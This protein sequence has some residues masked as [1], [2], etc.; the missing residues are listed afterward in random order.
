MSNNVDTRVVEMQFNNAQ[1]EQGVSQTTSTLDKLKKAL[2]FSGSTKGFDEVNS[3]AHRVDLEFL[4]RRFGTLGIAG[5]TAIQNITNRLV[6]LGFKIK[7]TFSSS[8]IQGGFKRALNIEQAKFQIEGLHGVWDETSKG[9]KEGSK[10]IREAT[11]EAVKGTAYGLD[12]AAR[13]ASQLLASGIND[14]DELQTH[15]QSVAGVAAMTGGS[16]SEIGRIFTQTAGQGAMMGEQLMELSARGL[17]AASTLSDYFSTHSKEWEKAKKVL[18]KNDIEKLGGDLKKPTEAAI[19]DIAS[20]RGITFKMFSDA[21]NEAFGEHAKDANKTYTGSLMNMK[22]ALARIGADI[23]GDYLTNMRDIFNALTPVIDA[24]HTVMGPFIEDINKVQKVL[25]SNLILNLGVLQGILE[26]GFSGAEISGPGVALAHIFHGIG[27]AVSLVIDAF[28]VFVSFLAPIGG[29]LVEIAGRVGA[30]ISVLRKN[31][32]GGRIFD[33]ARLKAEEWGNKVADVILS[34]SDS[35]GPVL[36]KLISV[37]PSIGTVFSKALGKAMEIGISFGKFIS[38]FFS[39]LAEGVPEAIKL[40]GKGFESIGGSINR[41]TGDG[42]RLLNL[43][44]AAGIGVIVN[45]LTGIGRALKDPG[46]LLDNFFETMTHSAGPFKNAMW[47]VKNSMLQLQGALKAD[48]LMKIA[49]S[50]GIMAASLFLL[51]SI[52]ADKLALALGGLAGV[53]YIF[54]GLM[55]SMSSLEL[56]SKGSLFQTA[57]IAALAMSIE[58]FAVAILILVAGVKLLGSM[59]LDD[60]AKGLVGVGVLMAGVIAMAKLLGSENPAKMM[61]GI[62][63]MIAIAIA[64]D[65]LANAVKKLGSL[66]TEELIKGLGSVGLLMGAVAGLSHITGKIK[67][68]SGAAIFMIAEAID[69]LSN[70]VQKFAKM[71]PEELVKGLAAVGSM[72]LAIAGMSR[73][74]GSGGGILLASA[75]MLIMAEAMKELLPVIK[76]FGSMDLGQIA[77]G[78]GVLVGAMLSMAL[79][80]HLAKG[81]LSGSASILIM[82]MAVEKFAGALNLISK[83]PTDALTK[84]ILGLAIAFITIGGIAAILGT[85]AA[86]PIMIFAGAVAILGV[87]LLAAGVGLSA[88]AAG[89]STLVVLGSAGIHALGSAIATFISYIPQLISAVGEGIVGLAEILASNAGTFGDLAVSLIMALVEGLESSI[90]KIVETGAKLI[91]SFLSGVAKNISK[92]TAMALEVIAKFLDGISSNIGKVI[93]SATNL[94]INFINGMADALRAHQNEIIDAF[95]NIFEAVL[96]FMVT[97]L[98]NIVELIPGLGTMLADALEDIKKDMREALSPEEGKK[99]GQ[100]YVE[101]HADGMK[102]GKKKTRKAAKSVKKEAVDVLKDTKELNAAGGGGGGAWSNGLGSQRKHAKNSAKVLHNSAHSIL[103]ETK[104]YR[105]AGGGGGGAYSDGLGSKKKDA[106]RAGRDLRDRGCAGTSGAERAFRR[107]GSNAGAGFV[108]GIKAWLGRAFSAGESLTS[109]GVSGA[110]AGQ[111]SNS[112]AKDLIKQG[113]FAVMGY[114]VGV[115]KNEGMA[116]SAMRDLTM[117]SANIAGESIKQ[118]YDILD[119]SPDASPTIRPVVDLSDVDASADYISRALGQRVVYDVGAINSI[120]AGV[121]RENARA[122]ELSASV[123]NLS[124][125]LDR[126]VDTMNA[127]NLINNITVNGSENPEE[128]ANRMIEE[129]RLYA[130]TV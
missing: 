102:D 129:F 115:K 130:R 16:Y 114:V 120:D 14:T 37:I 22:A 59:D 63:G 50:I 128:F 66:N 43:F 38:G 15:M 1:F 88:F 36:G 75:G 17:N 35:I 51:S 124:K 90:G 57:Q 29:A 121:V 106:Y 110:K 69:V 79:I 78:I 116:F 21:L 11:L 74:M 65:I 42:D 31:E 61:K 109:H 111:H 107:E 48:I 91:L 122:S 60:L 19:R 95:K 89:V 39:A 12:E 101:S 83:I 80:G 100:K 125:R 8:I 49:K 52:P 94:I 25:A 68:T 84:S 73:L 104:E 53:S 27:D 55:R 32:L 118:A 123:D 98:Q 112:P 33:S 47:Q 87:G 62:T 41:I 23:A 3:A 24:T 34:I 119:S 13:V 26:H 10:T 56:F 28:S 67:V 20:K 70:S 54:A 2:N 5:A 18:S 46:K 72:M 127:R 82:S 9:F 92:I 40:L 108:A 96:E 81:T 86:G 44:S 76:E 103:K 97:I 126:V 7:H 117:T 64:I 45:N 6:D 105:A 71:K 4:Q 113:K 99:T 93:D 85:V 30:F 77:Q 58:G